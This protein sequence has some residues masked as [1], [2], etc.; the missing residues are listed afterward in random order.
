MLR[1]VSGIALAASAVGR[2]TTFPIYL[3]IFI[4]FLN[5]YVFGLYLA[6]V[7][8]RKLDETISGYEPTITIII[9]LF[10]EGCSIYDTILSL[11]RLD[12]P[13]H[14]LEVI[15]VDD[16]STDDSYEWAAKAAHEFSNVLGFRV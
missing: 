2:V 14:K 12:Y 6:L 11:V 5:R 3:F 9:P 1:K 4:V 16:C 15:V 8:G 13:Q 7:R 10:N